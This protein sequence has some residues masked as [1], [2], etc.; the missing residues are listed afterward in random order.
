[1]DCEIGG[2]FGLEQFNG[3]EYYPNLIALNSARNALAYLIRAK[4]IKKIYIPYYLCDS[5]SAICKREHCE[6]TYYRIGEDFLPQMDNHLND[7]EWLYVVN[8]YGQLC[9][10]RF[11]KEKFGRIIVDNVQDFFRE[12]VEGIDTIYSCRKYFGVPDGGYL[13]TDCRLLELEVDSS[14][15]RMKHILGRLEDDAS[16]HYDEYRKNE[17]TINTLD[18]MEMS[19][20][21][22]NILRAIDYENV[23]NRRTVNY[24]ILCN[25]LM[26]FN[27]LKLSTPKGPF[28]Y[29]FYVENGMQLKKQ[30]AERKIYVPTLWP[31]ARAFGGLEQEFSENILPLP[32]DQRYCE[33]DMKNVINELCEI[34]E[35]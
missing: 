6:Y 16:S 13:S 27:K 3:K 21:T 7:N 15:N 31:E 18:L 12:P 26:D 30:L 29:P 32:C 8:Y 10:E 20:I 22:H 5:I 19:S 23:I 35:N 14:K 17:D 28:S 2:F 24:M 11:L 34:I 9:D 25:A 33:R 1:M 4:N